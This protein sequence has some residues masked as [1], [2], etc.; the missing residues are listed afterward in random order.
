MRRFEPEFTAVVFDIDQGQ[1]EVVLNERDAEEL[2]ID[3]LDRVRLKLGKKEV[4]A[5]VDIS[6]R[7]IQPGQVGLFEEVAAELDAKNGS[8][9]LLVS[10]PRPASL[11]AIRKKLDGGI[12]EEH[13]I[14]EIISDLMHEQLSQAE[15]AAFVAGIYTRGMNIEETVSLTNAIFAS[16]GQMTHFKTP[17]VSEHSIGGVAGDR[18]SMILVPIIASLGIVIPKTCTRAIS[19]AAGTADVMEVLCPV[20]LSLEQAQKVVEKTGGCIALG[21]SMDMAAADDKLIKIRNPLRLDPKPLLLSSILAKKKAEGA[22]YVLVDLPTGRGAKLA[23]AEEARALGRDFEALGAHLGMKIECT[24]TD[25]SEPLSPFAGPALEARH[26]LNLLARKQD[27]PLVEKAL[28][29]SGLLISLVRGFTKEDGYL[30]AKH[31]FAS[32]KALEKFWEIARGQGG[33]EIAPADIEV[34]GFTHLITSAEQGKIAHVDNHAVSRL[35]RALGA[36][37]DKRAGIQLHVSKGQQIEENSPLVTLYA[38]SKEKLAFGLEQLKEI[39]LVE[40]ERIVLDVV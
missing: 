21:G 1:N 13:E 40:I 19:S 22:D 20:D 3:V 34:G 28:I 32:G 37:Q 16:G 8:K 30:M 36:P 38:S 11:D 31:Q 10:A 25:G 35:C 17:V 26:V 18:S 15:L 7:F 2:Q 24:V 5:I 29:M 14:S 4:L 39:N 33:K 9:I 27:G 23:T 6:H 12:L